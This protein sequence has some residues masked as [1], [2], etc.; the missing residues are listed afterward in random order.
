MP[1]SLKQDTASNGLTS[2]D[3]SW[4][5][6]S[7]TAQK[8]IDLRRVDI[9][10]DHWYP[11]AWA[12]E[13]KRGKAHGVKFAGDPVVLVRT[14]AGKVFAL[15]DRC[16][17]RQVPLHLGVVNGDSIQCCYHGWTFDCTGRCINVPYLDRE[18]LPNGVRSYPCR[19]EAGLIFIFPGDPLLAD[20]VP[21]PALGSVNDKAYKTRRFDR[22]VKCHYSFLHENLMDMNHQFLHRKR[23]GLMKMR[24]AK[25]SR[26]EDWIEVHYMFERV[27]GKQPI[28]E[29]LLFNQ[30]NAAGPSADES[31]DLTVIRT[32]YPYQTLSVYT[33][34][35]TMVADVWFCYVP[36][37]AEQRASRMFGFLSIRR[38]KI[39]GILDVAWP[40]LL[41]YTDIVLNEDQWIVEREQE[42]HD[43]QGEDLNHEVF[44]VILDLRSMLRGRGAQH[45]RREIDL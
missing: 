38:P 5:S 2:S 1:V 26:G 11:V 45:Q 10:P 14:E 15:E 27:K 17:H 7:S 3:T 42:A 34:D 18:R 29:A 43:W 9:H 20:K 8:P 25:H 13:V 6:P 16:A 4:A 22:E 31:T 39:F 32:V 41:W 44:P 33:K 30:R 24:S 12:P 40:L 28:G 21:F 36:L 37:D 19:E 23:M 35:Q